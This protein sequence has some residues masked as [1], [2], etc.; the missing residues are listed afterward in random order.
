MPPELHGAGLVQ[1]VLSRSGGRLRR[2]AAFRQD[3]GFG[4]QSGG[5]ELHPHARC[6]GRLEGAHG[7]AGVSPDG[8]FRVDGR[9]QRDAVDRAQGLSGAGR[10]GAAAAARGLPLLQGVQHHVGGVLG[11]A[12][13]LQLTQLVQSRVHGFLDVLRDTEGLR[14]GGSRR[15]EA[16]T[17]NME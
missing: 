9:P 11:G 6:D 12:L 5:F 15:E 10:R 17:E 8:R 16:E 7:V 14:Y 2:R 1:G 13:A 4:P 3:H